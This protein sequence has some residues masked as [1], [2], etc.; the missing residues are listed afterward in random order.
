LEYISGLLP[1]KFK[2]LLQ[3]WREFP[4][5]FISYCHEQHYFLSNLQHYYQ[6]NGITIKL[7]LIV[8]AKNPAI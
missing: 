3:V 5:C 7:V 6:S 8:A 4:L 2:L 1:I